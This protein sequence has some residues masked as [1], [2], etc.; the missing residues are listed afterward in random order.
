MSVC[1]SSSFT[2]LHIHIYTHGE[3]NNAQ[4]PSRTLDTM[5]SFTSTQVP[6][7]STVTPRTV[8]CYFDS[9]QKGAPLRVL[10]PDKRA[11]RHPEAI[12]RSEA[13]KKKPSS[14]PH[15]TLP[16]IPQRRPMTPVDF[17]FGADM[18]VLA[19]D[20]R[21]REMHRNASDVRETGPKHAASALDEDDSQKMGHDAPFTPPPAWFVPPRKP[22]PVQRSRLDAPLPQTPILQAHSPRSVST[23]TTPGQYRLSSRASIVSIS[24]PRTSIET[25]PALPHS[26]DHHNGNGNSR[27]KP[28]SFPDMFDP[29]A[30][31]YRV[32]CQ[33]F[34]RSE[35]CPHI[36]QCRPQKRTLA[37]KVCD[38][39]LV[40]Y[41][42]EHWKRLEESEQCK[43][44]VAQRKKFEAKVKKRLEE[45][46]QRKRT[47]SPHPIPPT[48][49]DE[50]SRASRTDRNMDLE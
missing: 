22:V 34:G 4:H 23:P 1:L 14:L 5:A 49:E 37:E 21:E 25:T 40:M 20:E 17:M 39:S 38:L 8:D 42:I 28:Y 27:Q 6:S 12:R 35:E 11:P 45:R 44:V 46:K 36:P 31:K 32:T 33:S 29:A 47:Y 9:S 30:L 24:T 15:D 7:F 16:Y 19:H 13:K 48:Y 26:H 50:M 18:Y 10:N 41:V 2:T 43:C 3:D